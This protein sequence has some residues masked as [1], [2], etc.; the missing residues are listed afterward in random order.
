M[1]F[2]AMPNTDGC[3]YF[4]M[5]W[6]N[7]KPI[8]D[9]TCAFESNDGRIGRSNAIMKVELFVEK[10]KCKH[11]EAFAHAGDGLVELRKIEAAEEIAERLAKARNVTYLPG[12]QNTLLNLPNQQ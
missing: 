5:P 7:L 6:G 11:F 12:N 10:K 3:K 4:T 9:I 1:I 8:A 2:Q